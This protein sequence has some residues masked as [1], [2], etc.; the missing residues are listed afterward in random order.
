MPRGEKAEML[1]WA[2]N[3]WSCEKGQRSEGTFVVTQE[4]TKQKQALREYGMHRV[5]RTVF[6]CFMHIV[7]NMDLFR[8]HRITES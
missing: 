1:S 3:A 2:D 4:A 8:N 6:G 5:E 7:K